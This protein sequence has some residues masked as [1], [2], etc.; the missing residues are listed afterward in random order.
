MTRAQLQARVAELEAELLERDRALAALASRQAMEVVLPGPPGDGARG[1]APHL[2]DA[3]GLT[4]RLLLALEP[5]LRRHGTKLRPAAAATLRLHDNPCRLPGETLLVPLAVGEALAGVVDAAADFSRECY[6]EGFQR[7]ADL[8]ARVA[9]GDLDLGQL[10]A[11]VEKARER[12]GQP[13]RARVIRRGS[14]PRNSRCEP[15]GA[16]P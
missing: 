16:M 13:L 15:G 6:A 10:E 3:P 7:G 14:A 5:A 11:G 1:V 4:E 9:R 2:P 12:Q 8:L